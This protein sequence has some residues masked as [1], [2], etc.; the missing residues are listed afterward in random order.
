M[1]T[2]QLTE[3]QLCMCRTCVGNMVCKSC[4]QCGGYERQYTSTSACSCYVKDD[5]EDDK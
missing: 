4:L 3:C 1:V 5:A 2:E